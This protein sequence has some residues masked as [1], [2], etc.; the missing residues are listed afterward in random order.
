MRTHNKPNQFRSIPSTSTIIYRKWIKELVFE[1]Q[2]LTNQTPEP[3]FLFLNTF[4]SLIFLLGTVNTNAFD[5]L[6]LINF[7]PRTIPGNVQTKDLFCGGKWKKCNV[8]GVKWNKVLAYGNPNSQLSL[9][10]SYPFSS[11]DTSFC[12]HFG[13][14]AN[15]QTRQYYL[16]F[17]IS[18]IFNPSATY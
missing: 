13:S 14:S 6:I 15:R 10:K 17:C 2:P 5:Y 1:T 3:F 12:P 11:S 18:L 4:L 9:Q 16:N 8:K 7:V